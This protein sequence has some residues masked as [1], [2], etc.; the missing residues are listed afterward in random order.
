MA[1]QILVVE[2]EADLREYLEKILT[3][4]GYTVRTASTGSTALKRLEKTP[5][6][7]VLLDLMLPDMKGETICSEIKRDYPEIAVIILTAKARTQ[8]VVQGLNLGADDYIGKPFESEEL[9]ARIHACLRKNHLDGHLITIGDLE[10]D[11]SIMQVTRNKK[12][13]TLTP[14]EFK[15]LEYLM[16]HSGKV[17][18]RDAILNRIW[19]YSPDV[20]SRA[21]DVYVG[22][23]RKKIDTGHKKKLIHSIRGFGYTL[24]A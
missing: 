1:E 20:E 14:K 13:I 10:L 3:D 16:S 22:Y 15:L 21:V 12:P 4:E 7:L 17:L 11:N 18:S 19:L 2:D 5:P 23:L 6:D 9:L 8:D 24:K